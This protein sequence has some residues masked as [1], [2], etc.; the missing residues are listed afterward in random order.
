MN[1]SRTIGIIC[2]CM[3][4]A[5]WGSILERGPAVAGS[6]QG[7]GLYWRG[8]VGFE[9]YSS[10]SCSD[11]SLSAYVGLPVNWE[12][13]GRCVGGS[14]SYE[15]VT[16]DTGALPPGLRLFAP[17]EHLRRPPPGFPPVYPRIKGVPTRAGTWHLRVRFVGD[18]ILNPAFPR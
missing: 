7:S 8:K 6:H 1:G 11:M 2:I 15:D 16:V 18:Y 10:R 4:F 13:K 9:C 17:D 12:A 14:W 3:I 5:A